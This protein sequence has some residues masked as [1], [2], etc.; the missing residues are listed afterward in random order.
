M[1]L[2]NVDANVKCSLVQLSVDSDIGHMNAMR[3]VRVNV[4]QKTLRFYTGKTFGNH[5]DCRHKPGVDI[6]YL[7]TGVVGLSWGIGSIR[8]NIF[9]LLI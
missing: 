3:C 1:T 5:H 8:R 9:A 2:V 6:G 4:D 7:G